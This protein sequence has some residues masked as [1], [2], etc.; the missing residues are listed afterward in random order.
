[1]AAGFRAARGGRARKAEGGRAWRGRAS[2]R[3]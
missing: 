1:M 3:A 2:S